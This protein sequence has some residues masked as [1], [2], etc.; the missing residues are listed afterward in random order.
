MS[1]TSPGIVYWDLII[2]GSRVSEGSD[3]APGDIRAFNVRTGE[4]AWTFHTIPR[5]GEFGY[6]SW[7]DPDAWK[8]IGGANSW[9]GMALDK[10]RGIV[11]VPTGSASPIFTEADARAKICLPIPCWHSMPERES[12]YGIFSRYTTT[13]GT[14]TCPLR[15]A[16]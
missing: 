10:E 1:A 4:L 15:P 7:D 2:L 6:E 11:Y 9:A 14:A 12:V 3:A 8:R 5:P 16:W 13:S